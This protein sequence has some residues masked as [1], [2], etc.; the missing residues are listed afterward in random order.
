MID[1]IKLV[2]AYFVV[3]L[4]IST[5]AV[6]IIGYIFFLIVNW[7]ELYPTFLLMIGLFVFG[8]LFANAMLFIEEYRFK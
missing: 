7:D 5:I 2:I 4:F 8:I 3:Y 6:S 1:K